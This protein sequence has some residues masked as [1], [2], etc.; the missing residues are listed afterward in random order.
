M[1]KRSILSRTLALMMVLTLTTG[2]GNKNEDGG[3]DAASEPLRVAVQSFYC[4]SM[5]QYIQDQGLAEQAGLDIEWIVFNGGAAINEAMGEWDV[6]VTGGAFVYALAN[7]GCKLVAHQVNGTDGN[8]VCARNGDPL[9]DAE[10]PEEMADL[11]L[12]KTLLTCIGTTGHYTLNLWLESIGL[13]PDECQIMNLEIANV[14][15]SWVAGEGDY[16]VLTEPYCYYDMDEMN[17]TVVATLDSIGGELYEATVCTKDAYENRYDDVVK[18][19]E[20]LYQACDALAADEDLAVQTVVDWYTNCG[21]T[22]APE[23]ARTSI[24]GKPMIT[25][26]EAKQIA[27]GEFAESYAAWY[28]EQELIDQTGLENVKNNIASDVFTDALAN[29]SA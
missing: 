5:A 18:F 2:C 9:I 15:S 3:G 4:S 13:S 6:S 26:E 28:A 19:V 10:T 7:Y 17:T 1:K 21:K 12:G 20:I 29:L 25:S 16:C 23:E 27:L 22:L 8:Y 24:Q 14:Y 11:V